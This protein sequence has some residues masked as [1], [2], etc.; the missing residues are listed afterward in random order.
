MDAINAAQMAADGLGDDADQD[1]VDAARTLVTAAQTAVN[2]LGADDKA[3]LSSQVASANTMVTAAQ[4]TLDGQMAA[5]AATAAAAT[6]ETELGVEAG[7]TGEADA[8]LGG[9]DTPAI[10][11]GEQSE[12]AYELSIERDRM[13]TTVTITVRGATEDDDVE[14]MQA[15]NLAG[16]RTMH[17]REMEADDD[18][19]VVTEVVIVAT[20]IQAPKAVAF[21]TVHELDANP[22]DATP[23][24][25]QSLAIDA[26]NLAMIATT[27]ITSTGAAEITLKAAVPDDDQTMDVDETVAAFETDATFDGAPGTLKCAGTDDALSRSMRTAR[28]LLLSADG[29]SPPPMAP[30][31][32]WT[33]PTICTTASG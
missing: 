32:M 23:S 4:D 33:M 10:V 20:D 12:G 26:E 24:V 3:R 28:S 15:M 1:A 5:A 27:G 8:G 22:N 19:N 13:A 21:A 6:K 30:R 16:G 31:W 9:T 14:F 25:D 11:D 29:N 17:V 7:E 2:A 18:G